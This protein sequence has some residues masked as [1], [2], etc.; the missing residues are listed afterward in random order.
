MKKLSTVIILFSAFSASNGY[1]V[2]HTCKCTVNKLYAGFV[3]GIGNSSKSR[4]DCDN[5]SSYYIGSFDNELVRIR[6]SMALAAKMAGNQVVLQYHSS[7][8]AK[9]CSVASSDTTVFPDGMYIE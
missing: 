8:G 9:N 5:G 1:A 2:T 6:H 4:I 3:G 7:D